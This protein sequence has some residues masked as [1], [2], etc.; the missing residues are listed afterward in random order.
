MFGQQFEV[1]P[2]SH[3]F[4]HRDAWQIFNYVLRG[5]SA[6]TVTI[7]LSSADD[8]T[9]SAFARLV[10]LRRELLRR[11]GDLRLCGLRCRAARL[12]QV[13][14]L[15]HVLPLAGS[16]EESIAARYFRI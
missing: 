12:Y 13:S 9:T 11:G 10:L 2:Q 6:R 14:R 5:G 3:C 16:C 1:V 7:D 8:A 4:A 15:D